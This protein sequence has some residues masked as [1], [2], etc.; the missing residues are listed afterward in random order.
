MGRLAASVTRTVTQPLFERL[1]MHAPSSLA[2]QRLGAELRGRIA[3]G[4]RTFLIG[5]GP[6]GHNAGAALVEVRGDGSLSLVC[7]EEEERYRGI[8]HYNR[9]P[10]HA[11]RAVGERL[12]ELGAA[13]D[14]VL[15]AFTSWDY[16]EF[17]AMIAR[18]AAEELPATAITHPGAFMHPKLVVGGALTAQRL[19]RQ[20]GRSDRLPAIGVRHHDAH[21]GGAFALSP[22]AAS[23][24]PVIVSVIDGFGDDA[25]ISLYLA[26]GG[27]LELWARNDSPYDSLGGIYAFISSTQGGW[28]ILSSEGRYMGA[29][30]WGDRNRLTNPYYQPLRELLHLRPDGELRLNRAL[31][32]WPRRGQTVPYTRELEELL[33][34]PVPKEQ[35][36]H[37]DAVLSVDDVEHAE[38]TRERVDKAAALQLVF[39]DGLFHVLGNAIRTTGS[40]RIVLTGGTALNCAANEKL[41]EHFDEGY[42]ERYLGE[43]RRLHMWVPPTPGDAGQPFG[44]AMW[45]AL[46]HGARPGAPMRHAFLCGRPPAAGAIR[47][48]IDARPEVD[49][50]SLGNV[51]RGDREGVA[52]LVAALI[53]EDGVIGLYQGAAETGPRALGHRSILANP[54][55]RDT[56]EQINARVKY[57]ERIRPLAPMVTLE[58][59]RRLF[60]LSE[61][62]ADDDY[63]A[64]GYMVITARAR[65]DALAR[66]PAVVH[67]DGTS[68]LQI[69]REDDALTHALL[70]ALGRRLGVEAA[71]NTS[72]NVGA[73]I[74]HTPEQALETLCRA[75]GMDGLV[76]VADDGEAWFAWHENRPRAARERLARVLAAAERR[77]DSVAGTGV[78]DHP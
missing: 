14:E 5:I 57:R 27:R 70:K 47:S 59:A 1:D 73:P 52:D 63:N 19:S 75:K 23:E 17:G 32:N 61:G 4:E 31:A 10:Y 28:P 68:R 44:A 45:F 58:E 67:Q 6:S 42:Y 53:A 22:F 40:D 12:G 9:Y 20:L 72:L 26:R 38:L 36:W 71:V 69:V 3:R 18:V 7:N 34:P 37:P 30:A 55:R 78:R 35:M 16:V 43:S 33:G 39:E 62:A 48:A 46:R 11:V 56:L 74:A 50:M 21:A 49:R 77:Q 2:A 76:M 24:D 8:K 13:Q 29:A 25:A 64:Y 41:L 65:P 51:E 66:V 60:E 15:A 54:C